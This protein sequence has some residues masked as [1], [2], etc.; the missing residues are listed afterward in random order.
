MEVIETSRTTLSTHHNWFNPQR[1]VT[2]PFLY[3]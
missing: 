1:H 2:G 3:V